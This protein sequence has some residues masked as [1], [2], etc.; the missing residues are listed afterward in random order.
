MRYDMWKNYWSLFFFMVITDELRLLRE[1][2]TG[3]VSSNIYCQIW[4][5]R[6]CRKCCFQQNG[7]NWNGQN[8][9]SKSINFTFWWCSLGTSI[10]WFDPFGSLPLIDLRDLDELKEN[11]IQEIHNLTSDILWKVMET[12]VH[13]MR[14]L[15]LKNSGGHLKDIIFK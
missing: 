5:I 9:Y 4:K 1:I 12:D 13:G 6:T 14:F 15:V 2:L 3:N 11:T 10:P 7:D 8:S